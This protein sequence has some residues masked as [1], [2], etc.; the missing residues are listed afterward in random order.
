ML[1]ENRMQ[2]CMAV[3]HSNQEKIGLAK[4]AAKW[5]ESKEGKAWWTGAVDCGVGL[6]PRVAALR[7]GPAL[8]SHALDFTHF[9]RD[10]HLS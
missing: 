3:R 10:F 5:A 4:I 8:P 2:V 1:F 9:A 6:R 7:P